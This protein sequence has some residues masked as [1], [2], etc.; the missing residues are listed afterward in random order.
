MTI[1][2]ILNTTRTGRDGLKMSLTIEDGMFVMSG[3][4]WG[5]HTLSIAHTDDR[6]LSAHWDGYCEASGWIRPRPE[7]GMY[8]KAVNGEA[9]C[10]IAVGSVKS[11]RNRK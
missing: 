8:E 9:L 3:G 11:W 6:R 4:K 2:S 1:N 10:F 7:R 5:R